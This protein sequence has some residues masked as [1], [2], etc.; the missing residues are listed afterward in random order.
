MLITAL[1]DGE[2]DMA[3][4]GRIQ[5]HLDM[6]E[7]CE[8]RRQME[9]R[10]KRFLKRRLAQVDTPADLGQRIRSALGGLESA[11]DDEEMLPGGTKPDAAPSEQT[12]KKDGG[13]TFRLP[14]VILVTILTAMMAFQLVMKTSSNQGG[15]GGSE[16][17][18]EIGAV[19]TAANGAGIFQI[20]TRNREAL[21]AWF[22]EQMGTSVMI[23]DLSSVGV[24]PVGGR[25]INIGGAS[26][27]MVLYKDPSEPPEAHPVTVMQ[28]AGAPAL[29]GFS[30]APIQ[31]D[32]IAVLTDTLG[33]LHMASFSH[34]ER[35][36]FLVTERPLEGLLM[37]VRSVLGS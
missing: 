33:P 27:A 31:V 13:R 9:T 25:V 18:I 7:D 19:H 20:M 12:P 28:G 4:M 30:D 6:C 17:G 36:W 21:G 26:M 15:G 5:T 16:L 8:S 35:S 1:V 24:A 22:T 34:R 37:A 14:L 29:D 11:A 2:L 10:L 3:E 32:G 23:S